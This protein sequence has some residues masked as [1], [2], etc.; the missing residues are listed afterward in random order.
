[1]RGKQNILKRVLIQNTGLNLGLVLRKLIGKGTPRRFQGR[2]GASR[3]GH[4]MRV[5]I[6][7][8]LLVIPWLTLIDK[9]DSVIDWPATMAA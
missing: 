5:E 9:N 1:M 4:G 2:M 7:V 8:W 3:A 6:Q